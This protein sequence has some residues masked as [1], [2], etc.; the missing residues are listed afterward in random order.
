MTRSAQSTRGT[1][2][3]VATS[4]LEVTTIDPS[5]LVTYVDLSASG[6]GEGEVT[7]AVPRR[8]MKTIILAN[9]LGTFT[10]VPVRP[11]DTTQGP[12]GNTTPRDLEGGTQHGV[13]G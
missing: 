10:F 4:Q 7:L 11:D 1:F 6:P 9:R 5:A 3:S 12:P 2:A 8:E 13:G